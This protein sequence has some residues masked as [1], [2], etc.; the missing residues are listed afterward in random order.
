MEIMTKGIN[1][2]PREIGI[3]GKSAMDTSSQRE[4]ATFS[5]QSLPHGVPQTSREKLDTTLGADFPGMCS[6]L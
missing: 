1:H 5:K 6:T 4:V 3:K 2:N